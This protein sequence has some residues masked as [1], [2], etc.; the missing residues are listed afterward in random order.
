MLR[1]AHGV[2]PAQVLYAHTVNVSVH[3]PCIELDGAFAEDFAAH[4]DRMRGDYALVVYDPA[5]M[6]PGSVS[7]VEHWLPAQGQSAV[8]GLLRGPPVVAKPPLAIAGLD[9]FDRSSSRI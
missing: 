8:L 6:V 5:R 4:F 1:A 2:T 3:A 9:G 7:L